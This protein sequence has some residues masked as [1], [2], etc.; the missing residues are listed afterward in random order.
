MSGGETRRLI[1]TA[2][3]LGRAVLAQFWFRLGRLP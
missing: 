3:G 1:G 2:A